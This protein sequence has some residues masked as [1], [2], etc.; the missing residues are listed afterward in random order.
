MI[1]I[2]KG[3]AWNTISFDEFFKL[4]EME[5]RK[6][7][8]SDPMRTTI[9]ESGRCLNSDEAILLLEM[10]EAR[11][12][13]SIADH[14]SFLSLYQHSKFRQHIQTRLDTLN[15]GNQAELQKLGIDSATD[16]LTITHEPQGPLNVENMIL[17]PE[18]SLKCPDTER[19]ITVPEFFL[20]QF[21]VT[22]EAYSRFV[23]DTGAAPPEEWHSNHPPP[24]LHN[25]PVVEISLEQARDYAEWSGCRLPTSLEW[26]SAARRPDNRLL[27]WTGEQWD[28]SRCNNPETGPGSTTPVDAFPDGKSVDGCMDLVGNVWEWTSGAA[29]FQPEEDGYTWVYGGSFRHPC[30]AENG[31]ARSQVLTSNSYPYLGFRCAI[32]PC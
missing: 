11:H 7:L 32:D 17:I 31:I 10:L 25:H 1:S 24:S 15:A 27:P 26:E 14:E 5:E 9:T 20:G 29:G 28:P 6:R 12:I 22:N 23:K 3:Y 19:Q 4:S 18:T 16:V 30:W 8:V 13:R 2:N 21:P